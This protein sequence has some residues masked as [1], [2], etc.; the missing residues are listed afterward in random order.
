MNQETDTKNLE[1]GSQAATARPADISRPAAARYEKPALTVFGKV[2][3]LVGRGSGSR[4]A[5]AGRKVS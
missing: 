5:T 4:D 1:L 3:D 2:V